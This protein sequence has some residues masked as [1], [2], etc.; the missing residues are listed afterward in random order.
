[1]FDEAT[2]VLQL[3]TPHIFIPIV[4]IDRQ[5]PF[6]TLGCFLVL[7]QRTMSQALRDQ[8]FAKLRFDLE[9]EIRFL[10]LSPLRKL[11]SAIA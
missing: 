9:R 5:E 3:V 11:A 7:R 2:Q 10:N 4:R 8:G 1:M 6:Q